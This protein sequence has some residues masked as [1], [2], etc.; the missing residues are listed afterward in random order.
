MTERS[1][2]Q[3][4]RTGRCELKA[5][6][7]RMMPAVVGLREVHSWLGNAP[8]RAQELV[9]NDLWLCDG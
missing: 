9:G 6:R 8:A 3:E 7:M 1:L 4:I 5:L 2:V